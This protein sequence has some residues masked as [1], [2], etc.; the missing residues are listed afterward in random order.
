MRNSIIIMFAM[1]I[2]FSNCYDEVRIQEMSY[3]ERYIAAKKMF[4]KEE[5]QNAK[6]NFE[7]LTST[8]RGTSFIDSAF[9]YLAYCHYNLQEYISAASEFNRLISDLP[10]SSLTDDAQYMI[11]MS[12]FDL[13]PKYS[14]DQEYTKKAITEFEKLKNYYPNS[15]YI[16]KANEMLKNLKNKLAK[17]D[18]KAGEQYLDL[19]NY[20]SAIIYF[21]SILENYPDS[22]FVRQALFKKGESL[23]KLEKFDEAVSFLDIFL[24]LYPDD[25]NAEK[26][27]ELI[28][29]INSEEKTDKN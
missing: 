27:K 11:G 14:L 19:K 4:E 22:D 25:E 28:K 26:A 10:A 17:K 18:L 6:L 3:D 8:A 1:I 12:Y 2:L 20:N 29:K 5:Y 13:S 7:I 21:N 24:N 15:Q 9:Y 23:Y 16:P